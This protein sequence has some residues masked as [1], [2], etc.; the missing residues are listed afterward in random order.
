[1]PRLAALVV[2]YRTPEQTI[3]AVRSLQASRRGVDDLIVVDNASGSGSETE[4]RRLGPGV[5]ILTSPRNLGFSGGNNLGIREALRRGADLICLVNSDATVDADCLGHLETALSDHIGIAGPLLIS[6]RPPHLVQSAGIHFSPLS[7][8]MRQR[9]EHRTVDSFQDGPC[10]AVDAISGC[11]MLIRR[12]VFDRIGLLNE[13]YFF[14]FEDV[15]FC[16]TARRAGFATVCV[17]K[18]KAVHDGSRTIGRR[19]ATRIYFATRN[20]LLLAARVAPTTP[21]RAA[22]RTASILGLNVAHA[23]LTS[24]A[25]RAQAMWGVVQGAWHHARGRYGPRPA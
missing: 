25:P 16:L 1:M 21:V 9:D 20:H 12:A 23:L 14:S 3:E 11:V 5:S 6:R 24:E 8:R 7:G 10:Y 2:N 13:T 22:V 17:P 15:D 19:S 4:L 18:A